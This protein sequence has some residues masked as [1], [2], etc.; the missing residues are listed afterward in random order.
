MVLTYLVYVAKTRVHAA[1]YHVCG[2]FVYIIYY[3]CQVCMNGTGQARMC[4]L[5]STDS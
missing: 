5:L 4:D 3:H 1:F 2:V